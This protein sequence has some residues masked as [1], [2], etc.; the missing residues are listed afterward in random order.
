MPFCDNPSVAMVALRASTGHTR[1]V[2]RRKWNSSAKKGGYDEAILVWSKNSMER[3]ARCL[4]AWM[5]EQEAIT[6]LL[7]HIPG[8]GEHTESQRSLWDATRNA[9]AA[10]PRYDLAVPT[11]APIP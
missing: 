4:L 1:E 3:L 11:L 8:H 10:R 7:G 6:T 2:S 5:N 9:N